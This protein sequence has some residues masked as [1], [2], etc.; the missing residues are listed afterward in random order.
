MTLAMLE[1]TPLEEPL[2][3]ANF[4]HPV[5]RTKKPVRRPRNNAGL[6]AWFAGRMGC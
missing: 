4:T 1:S 3:A 5:P 6:A 2:I